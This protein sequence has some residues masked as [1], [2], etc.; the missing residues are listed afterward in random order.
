[1]ATHFRNINTIA[2]PEQL[3]VAGYLR[4]INHSSLD[5]P[6]LIYNLCILFRLRSAQYLWTIDPSTLQQMK[7]CENLRKF[8]SPTFNIEGISWGF[9]LYP[10][11][12]SMTNVGSV[13]LFIRLMNMPPEWLYIACSIKLY[14]PEMM[15]AN[16]L[17]IGSSFSR[18]QA[19]GWAR[20]RMTVSEIQQLDSLSFSVEI[21]ILAIV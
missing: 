12:Q 6:P 9:M 18:R 14:C 2:R 21:K 1:M 15:T 16:V 20:N 10:N 4:S 8:L 19:I 17:R 11:G 5:V 13:D 7:N 3:L